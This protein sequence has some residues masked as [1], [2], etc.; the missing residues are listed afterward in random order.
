MIYLSTISLLRAT[1]AFNG[2]VVIH[3]ETTDVQFL[4]YALISSSNLITGM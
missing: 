1:T 2:Q 3:S 4:K